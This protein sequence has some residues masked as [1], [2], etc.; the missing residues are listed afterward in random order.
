MTY[1]IVFSFPVTVRSITCVVYEFTFLLTGRACFRRHFSFQLISA[2][3]AFPICHFLS[4]FFGYQGIYLNLNRACFELNQHLKNPVQ[5]IKRQ[6]FSRLFSIR[7]Q[8]STNREDYSILLLLSFLKL[9]ETQQ[10]AP[11]PVPDIFCKMY[12]HLLK[13]E[14]IQC[15]VFLPWGEE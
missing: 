13:P 2:V 15:N 8:T 10:Q 11:G 1:S 14:S 4:P 9:Q 3:S 12:H 7:T 5:T 6:D